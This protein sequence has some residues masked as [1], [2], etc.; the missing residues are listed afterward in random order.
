LQKETKHKINELKLVTLKFEHL[1]AI[2]ICLIGLLG[3]HLIE[4]YNSSKHLKIT[5]CGMNKRTRLKLV[6]LKS[7]HLKII[8]I[9]LMRLLGGHLVEGY[10]LIKH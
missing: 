2:F 9:H 5:Q 10:N 6:T 7:K 4:G 1:K 8:F 3:G